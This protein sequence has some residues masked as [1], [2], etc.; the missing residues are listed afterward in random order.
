MVRSKKKLKESQPLEQTRSRG[1]FS[2]TKRFVCGSPHCTVC[3]AWAL[4]R[5]HGS[6][7]LG[8]QTVTPRLY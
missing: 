1:S 6:Y 3:D 8:F 5:K 2:F 4:G 7:W